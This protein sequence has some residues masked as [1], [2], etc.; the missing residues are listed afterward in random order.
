MLECRKLGRRSPVFVPARR[1]LAVSWLPEKKIETAALYSCLMS[2]EALTIKLA[3]FARERD[4]EQFHSPKN[5]AVALSIEASELLEIFQWSRGQVD[6]AELN[7]PRVRARVEEELADVF[8][9]LL[10]FADLAKINLVEAAEAKLAANAIKYPADKF[11]GSDK[12][13]NEV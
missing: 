2:H 6:W 10:R 7:E 8:L 13:Y 1:P 9:Y 5:L 11:K 12:K 4:W 3:Q